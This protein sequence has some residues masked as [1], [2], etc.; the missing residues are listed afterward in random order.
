MLGPK[1]GGQYLMH[2]L[3]QDGVTRWALYPHFPEET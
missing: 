2:R 1:L 3:G